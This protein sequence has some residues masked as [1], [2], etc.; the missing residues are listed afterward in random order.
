MT[1]IEL[2]RSGGVA[3]ISLRAT[4]DTTAPDDPDAA[5]FDQALDGVDLRG[6]AGQTA[7][8]GAG[9]ERGGGA[10]AGQPDRFQYRLAVE[11]GGERHEVSF[12]E[13]ALPEGLRPVVDRLV[14]RA[15]RRGPPGGPRSPNG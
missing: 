2:V 15:R 1:R 4:V 3:G 5:W 9:A 11:R 12:G 10:G 6:L 7:E 14:Q 13:A 8:G